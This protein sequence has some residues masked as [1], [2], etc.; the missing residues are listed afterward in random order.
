M[1]VKL[2]VAFLS[3]QSMFRME[4]FGIVIKQLFNFIENKR[5]DCW[6]SPDQWCDNASKCVC[7][8]VIS[9]TVQTSGMDDVGTVHRD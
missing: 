7:A 5:E 8:C 6:I 4:P 3:L 1:K 2:L 9:I